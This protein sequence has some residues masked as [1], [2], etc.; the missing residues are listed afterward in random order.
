MRFF[1]R[2]PV[3]GGS[4]ELADSIESAQGDWRR[5]GVIAVP[6]SPER[7]DRD[8]ARV[9]GCELAPEVADVQLDL[10]ARDAVRVAPDDIEEL[11][12]RQH[13]IRVLD[14]GREQLELER[15]ELHGAALDAD[16]ALR[17]VD[18]DELVL[19][20][21]EQLRATAGPA[22]QRLHAGEQLLPPER[23]GDVVVCAR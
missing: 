22:E 17:I 10:V 18:R 11:V 2:P 5:S 12:T 20:R 13:A 1:T 4:G 21:L 8:A 15:G 19:V 3:T 9:V 16:A 14:E 7:L 6:E 23:L